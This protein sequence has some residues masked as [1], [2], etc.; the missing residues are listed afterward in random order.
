MQIVVNEA[1]CSGCRACEVACVARRDGRFGTAT[2][3]I[4][5][6]K[7]EA[8]GVDRASL[9]RQCDDAPCAAVCPTGAL[10]ADVAS[11]RLRFNA[12][13]CIACPAC[14]VA[15]PFDVL[16]IDATTGMPLV[17]DL[18]DGDPACVKR[19]ATGALTLGDAHRV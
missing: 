7:I 14:A 4:R 3:R 9:C 16:F 18:C 5:I 8:Q 10:V 1:L 15:C 11:H 12:D 6:V 13:D 2:A 19:C 17:C